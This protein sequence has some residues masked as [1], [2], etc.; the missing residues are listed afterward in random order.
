MGNNIGYSR[1]VTFSQKIQTGH[2]QSVIQISRGHNSGFDPVVLPKHESRG[3]SIE[4]LVIYLYAKGIS[5]SGI[6]DELR[7]I[8][9]ITLSTNAISISTFFYI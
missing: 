2:G 4:N 3:L 5:V 7:D 1:N 6:E 9:E 8:Y